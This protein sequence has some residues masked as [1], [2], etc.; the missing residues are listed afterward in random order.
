MSVRC[1]RWSLKN[2]VAA[3][4]A[5]SGISV[6][7]WRGQTEE[8]FWWCIGKCMADDNWQPNMVSPARGT[9]HQGCLAF[10]QLTSSSNMGHIAI[11]NDLNYAPMLLYVK[12]FE[13]LTIGMGLI[14]F[15]V[16]IARISVDIYKCLSQF[17]T[18]NLRRIFGSRFWMMAAMQPT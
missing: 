13:I 7:A 2:D 12:L 15:F 14:P 6:Y 10:G 9:E 18:F 3:A 1:F 11:S 17:V 8:D 4:V 5:A 16:F